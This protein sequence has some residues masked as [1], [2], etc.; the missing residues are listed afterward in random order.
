MTAMLDN[1]TTKAAAVAPR[2]ALEPNFIAVLA[3]EFR[4]GRKI[5]NLR[6]VLFPAL[7][8]LSQLPLRIRVPNDFTKSQFVPVP[9]QRLRDLRHADRH[10]IQLHRGLT[11]RALR[12]SRL[13]GGS[14]QNTCNEQKQTTHRELPSARRQMSEARVPDRLGPYFTH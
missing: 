9:G 2:I 13:N 7:R 11:G 8:C 1:Q 6:R 12:D 10:V 14:N 5:P 3:E 4:D